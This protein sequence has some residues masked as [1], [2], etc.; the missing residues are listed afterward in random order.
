MG[1]LD[2][3]T[4]NAGAPANGPR[5]SHAELIDRLLLLRDPADRWHVRRADPDDGSD[6]IAEWTMVDAEWRRVFGEAGERKVLRVLMRLDDAETTVRSLDREATATWDAGATRLAYRWEG[7]RGQKIEV[8]GTWTFGKKN[9]GSFG[10]TDA[11]H[12]STNELKEPLRAMVRD[13]GWVG[14]AWRSE[15]CEPAFVRGER[16]CRSL[17][18]ALRIMLVLVWVPAQYFGLLL[19]ARQPR[20]AIA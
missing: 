12:Y 14:T 6:L 18:W 11:T 17:I 16:S 3:I 5:L 7:F 4:G 19:G 1:V 2:F 20:R 15:G 13:A 10:K 9:D 8:G